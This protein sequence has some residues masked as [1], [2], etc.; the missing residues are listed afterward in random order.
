[1]AHH[2]FLDNNHI[3]TAHDHLHHIWG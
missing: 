1:M 2:S 3:P